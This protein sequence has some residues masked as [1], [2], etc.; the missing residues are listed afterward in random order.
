MALFAFNAD[1]NKTEP[2]PKRAADW[3]AREGLFRYHAGEYR[4]AGEQLNRAMEMYFSLGQHARGIEILIYLLRIRA[5]HEEFGEIARLEHELRDRMNSN[6]EIPALLRSRCHYVL[7]LC[8]IYQGEQFTETAISYFEQSID[9]ALVAADRSA[10]AYSLLGLANVS[11]RAGRYDETVSK[12]E[13]LETILECVNIPELRASAH[14]VRGLVC[15]ERGDFEAALHRF[16]DAYRVLRRYPHVVLY[17]Q[18][19]QAIGATYARKEEFDLA[20]HYLDLALNA[21]CD[22]ELPRMKRLVEG[23]LKSLPNGER[24]APEPVEFEFTIETETRSIRDREGR[25]VNIEGRYILRDLAL[26]MMSE[27]GRVFSKEEIVQL[28]WGE[29]YDMAKHDNKVYVT[30]RRL[31]LLLDATAPSR[32]SPYI[33]RT[34]AGYHFDPSAKVKIVG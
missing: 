31:R 26:K 7:G 9:Y 8:A 14:I 10:L 28:L 17:I 21:I 22:D 20:R 29:A 11:W 2:H 16:R 34:K 18:V 25:P 33:I 19:L 1:K 24:R 3:Y 12:L 30:V 23:T 13:K 32:R 15:R 4:R 5:E 6:I 27:P